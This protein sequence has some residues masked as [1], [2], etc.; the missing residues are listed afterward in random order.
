MGLKRRNGGVSLDLRKKN[1]RKIGELTW[2]ESCAKGIA[3]HGDWLSWHTCVWRASG[4]EACE[5]QEGESFAFLRILMLKIQEE[6]DSLGR[7]AGRQAEK[8]REIDPNDETPSSL[9]LFIFIFVFSRT[10]S[11]SF[12]H[13]LSD[14]LSLSLYLVFCR[15]HRP[16]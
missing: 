5:N 4:A 2:L 16:R 12:S 3:S 14:A 6:E 10:F 7:Q 8:E 1:E 11:S 15:S 13:F 9:F